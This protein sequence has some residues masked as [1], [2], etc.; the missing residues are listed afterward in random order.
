MVEQK[1]KYSRVHF[2]VARD[3]I[4]WQI[5]MAFVISQLENSNNFLNSL[6]IFS[7]L[8]SKCIL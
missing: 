6:T 4:I 5:Q 7:A 2:W 8:L 3:K 1:E